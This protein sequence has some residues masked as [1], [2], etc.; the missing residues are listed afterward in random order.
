VGPLAQGGFLLNSGWAG[1][2]GQTG[3][4]RHAAHV[5]RA[6]ARWQIPAGAERR[7][8]AAIHRGARRRTGRV[9]SSVPVPDAWLGWPSRRKGDRVY[10]GGGSR[11]AV[12]E[13][14]SPM[15]TLTPA[16]TF[17][18]CRPPRTHRFHRR[19]RA[20][21]RRPPDL[22]RGPVSRFGG[23]DQSAIG[24]GDR[25]HQDRPPAVPH[26]VPSRRQIVLRHHWAD[27]TLGHYDVA[28]GNQLARVPL[29]AHPTDMVWRRAARIPAEAS[30]AGRRAPVSWP[31]PTPT[32]STRGRLRGKELRVVESIKRLHDAAPAARHDAQ[33]AGLSPTASASTWPARTATWWRWW[34]SP[35]RSHVEGFI[36]TGWY[37]TA[38]R[39]LPSAR[40][41]C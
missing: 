25:A 21:S 33:R 40:W 13:F 1:P 17:P 2:G 4:A 11:A 23:G 29:G 20:L 7:I 41:W 5:H 28:S 39:A 37:P 27:G 31:P 16:R 3:P 32:A 19:R 9:V 34:T 38:A 10:V 18:V 14:T 15:A 12:F 24:H 22:R 8:Q 6:L 30:R 35:G 26:P 36:P